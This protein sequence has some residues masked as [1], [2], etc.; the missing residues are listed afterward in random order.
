MTLTS[1]LD[2]HSTQSHLIWCGLGMVTY[3]K[4]SINDHNY[5]IYLNH[6]V[7][8]KEPVAYNIP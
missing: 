6:T 7:A 3:D 2:T 4:T 5:S 1:E 8:V